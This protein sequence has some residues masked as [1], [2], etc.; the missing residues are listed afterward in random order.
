VSGCGAA[1]AY[2]PRMAEAAPR[3]I[4]DALRAISG[5]SLRLRFEVREITAEQAAQ[6][7]PPPTEEELVARFVAEF[8]A[9]EILPDPTPEPELES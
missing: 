2:N 1:A 8:D 3:S 6:A 4:A 9:E 7:T 5:T